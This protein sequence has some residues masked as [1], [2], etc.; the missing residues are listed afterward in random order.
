MLAVSRLTSGDDIPRKLG[1]NRLILFSRQ[2]V[3]MFKD[4]FRA[5]MQYSMPRD[6]RM[7]ESLKVQHDWI[8]V[9]V[10]KCGW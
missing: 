2:G 4:Q 5:V 3:L 10:T 1:I 7:S 8:C 9:K 6:G